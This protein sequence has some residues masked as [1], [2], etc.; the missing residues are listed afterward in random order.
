M[1]CSFVGAVVCPPSFENPP[2]CDPFSS[3]FSFA[4]AQ[5]QARKRA[6]QVLDLAA[7]AAPKADLV[8]LPE[9][10]HGIRHFWRLLDSPNVPRRLAEPIPGPT[11]KAAARIARKH[12]AHLVLSLYENYQNRIYNAVVLLSPR[13]KILAH[14]RKTHLACGEDWVVS[15]GEELLVVETKLGLIGIACGEDYLFPETACV[16]GRL[17]AEIVVCPS[18]VPIPELILAA[19]SLQFGFATLF[20]S[21]SSALLIDSSGAALAQSAGR[22]DLVLSTSFEPPA[23][24]PNDRDALESKLTGIEDPRARLSGRR[25]PELYHLLAERKWPE[26]KQLSALRA[27]RKKWAAF[28]ELAILW[29]NG[30]EL[31]PD[32]EL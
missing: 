5:E 13:G 16:L 22:R 24:V 7:K 19:R 25:R 15:P 30:P 26:G 6:E 32:W 14:Y 23:A 2:E 31:I 9:D 18:K 8:V 4:C 21:P 10:I 11:V 27:R 12:K 1:A 17:N 3:S 28:N 20:A 29:E